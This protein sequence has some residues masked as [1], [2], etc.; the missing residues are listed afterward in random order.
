MFNKQGSQHIYIMDGVEDYLT[1]SAKKHK[2]NLMYLAFFILILTSFTLFNGELVFKSAFGFTFKSEDAG[3]NSALI[4]MTASIACGYQML[5]LLYYKKICNSHY[6]GDKLTRKNKLGDAEQVDR[7]RTEIERI[8]YD[9][10]DASVFQDILKKHFRQSELLISAIENQKSPDEL[11]ASFTELAETIHSQAYE[12]IKN[13]AEIAGNA[14][15]D[16]VQ[17]LNVDNG[18]KMS[19]STLQHVNNTIYEQ[20]LKYI[21]NPASSNQH[22]L[23]ESY[24]KE[25]SEIVKMSHETV[26]K[27]QQWQTMMHQLLQENIDRHNKLIKLIE[28]QGSPSISLVWVEIWLPII[29]G[30]TMIAYSVHSVIWPYLIILG[31]PPS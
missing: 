30:A 13:D 8:N 24:L 4:L 27:N 3:I 2:R 9:V 16:R 7:F 31:T 18:K 11:K 19:S 29:F 25:H 1:E 28:E 15:F 5:M 20:V 23:V 17:Y 21:P 6:F 10:R 12:Q 22:Q 26:K 14:I